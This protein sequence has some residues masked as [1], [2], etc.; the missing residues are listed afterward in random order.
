MI[1]EIDV[2]RCARLMM[3]HYGDDAEHKASRRENKLV[4]AGDDR[5]AT[6]WRD[7]RLLIEELKRT[8]PD[9]GERVH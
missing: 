2:W 6:V 3:K 5:G 7:I 9:K 1:P 8:V 4:D